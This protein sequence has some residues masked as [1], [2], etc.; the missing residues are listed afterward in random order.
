MRTALALLLALNVAC[1]TREN[2]GPPQAPNAANPSVQ[3]DGVRARAEEAWRDS[4]TTPR[5]E[6]QT[7]APQAGASPPAAAPP[8]AGTAGLVPCSKDS[9]R[10]TLLPPRSTEDDVFGVGRGRSAFE[11]LERARVEAAKAIEVTIS[12]ETEDTQVSWQHS[13]NGASG[14]EY[15]SHIRQIERSQVERRL[16]SCKQVSA[17]Q[18]S[19]TEVALLASCSKRSALDLQLTAAARVLAASL[20]EGASVLFVPGTDEHGWITGLGEYA[21]HVL[22]GQL[23]QSKPPTATLLMTSDWAPTE[24]R[25][26]AR[27]SGA[28]HFVRLEHV[29]AAGNRV[30]VSVWLQDAVTDKATSPVNTFAVDLDPDQLDLLS[31]RGPLLPQKAAMDLARDI[32]DG[33]VDLRLSKSDL[34]EGE[35]VEFTVT[36][37]RPEYVY[38]FDLYEDGNVG[39]LVPSPDTPDNLFRPGESYRIPDENWKKNGDSLTACPIKGH[40]V[41]KETLKVVGSSTPLDLPGTQAAARTATTLDGTSGTVADLLAKLNELRRNG[42]AFQDASSTYV[43]HSRRGVRTACP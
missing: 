39:V 36:V 2:A 41:T 3:S 29:G 6:A 42:V 28:T 17:C 23:S 30:Q 9:D 33:R 27:H 32:G 22:R 31:I 19:A 34:T 8:G 12:A 26:L 14:D 25:E 10:W 24:L 1:G 16:A 4:R 38:V 13:G 20:A 37:P 5:D 21:V 18:V 35:P 40:L 15:R 7:S 11:A 43:V